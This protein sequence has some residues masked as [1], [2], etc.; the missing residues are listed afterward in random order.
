MEKL[1]RVFPAEVSEMRVRHNA[2]AGAV[3]DDEKELAQ[4]MMDEGRMNAFGEVSDG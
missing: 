3:T 2:P 1:A 4:R